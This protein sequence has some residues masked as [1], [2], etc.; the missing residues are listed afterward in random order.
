MGEGDREASRRGGVS[1]ISQ[2]AFVVT[3]G[4]DGIFVMLNIHRLKYLML[5]VE[6]QVD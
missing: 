6:A 2:P 4:G 3:D 5:T 1:S